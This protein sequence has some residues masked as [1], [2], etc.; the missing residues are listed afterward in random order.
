MSV[1]NMTTQHILKC[2]QIISCWTN[3]QFPRVNK[4]QLWKYT[5]N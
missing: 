3:R 2:G 1:A 5:K 4:A